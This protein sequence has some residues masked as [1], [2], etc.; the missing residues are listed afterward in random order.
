MTST[1]IR[2]LDSDLMM[3]MILHLESCVI[4]TLLGAEW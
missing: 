2:I 1:T 4:V 3:S